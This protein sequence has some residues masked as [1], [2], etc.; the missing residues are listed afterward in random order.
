M[1]SLAVQEAPSNYGMDTGHS[2]WNQPTS[3]CS[4]HNSDIDSTE[5]EDTERLLDELRQL[6]ASTYKTRSRSSWLQYQIDW[7]QVEAAIAE[8]E[9]APDI[10][11]RHPKTDEQM[12]RTTRMIE[13]LVKQLLL[14]SRKHQPVEHVASGPT[15]GFKEDRL[16]EEVEELGKSFPSYQSPH[17]DPVAATEGRTLLNESFRRI[18]NKAVSDKEIVGKIC[19]NLLLS[20][21]APNVHNYNAL[22]AGFNRIQRP[23]LAQAVVDSYLD[24]VKWPATQ[25]T[26]VCLLDHARGTNDLE[27]FREIVG[28]MRGTLEDGLH[29]RILHKG[30][31][32]NELGAQW[33]RQYGTHRKNAYVERAPRGNEVFN[34]LIRG[35][36]HFGKVDAASMSF[37]SCLRNGRLVPVDTIQELLT[38]CLATLDQQTARA[39]LKGLAKNFEKFEALIQYILAQSSI[40]VARR[41]ADT[42]YALFD[43][44]AMPYKPVVGTVKKNLLDVVEAFRNLHIVTHAKLQI[45]EIAE[46][47]R[48]VIERLGSGVPLGVEKALTLPS[49]IETSSHWDA[50][51]NMRFRSVAILAALTKRV[52]TLEEKTQ[53]IDAHAKVSM[54]KY[55]IGYDIDPQSC[56]PP[57]DWRHRRPSDEYPALFYALQ[58]IRVG[59]KP[60]TIDDVKLQLFFGIPDQHKADKLA[61]K[62]INSGRFTQLKVQRLVSFY[63]QGPTHFEIL[64]L[65][66][67]TTNQTEAGQLE[68]QILAAEETTKNTLFCHLGKFRQKKLKHSYNNWQDIPLAEIFK[69]HHKALAH[70]ISEVR[71]YG[72][73]APHNIRKVEEL[74]APMMGVASSHE[75]PWETEATPP[76]PHRYMNVALASVPRQRP[77]WSDERSPFTS[78]QHE[79]SALY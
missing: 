8:E 57:I 7:V 48:V 70:R 6:A 2:T 39:M 16:L 56:L 47:S 25:Q 32:F 59:H 61:A 68:E 74:E 50:Q 51:A 23:D 5:A 53:R 28:R 66:S 73:I 46:S 26:I 49:S 14:R 55:Q 71:R 40:R 69:Y 3:D 52:Q 33:V 18:F 45:Q 62:F 37:V 13:R 30:A 76:P 63:E 67:D 72:A 20:S 35:W 58:C 75:R 4:G 29:F 44:C 36:L 10:S 24:D 27:H 41:I 17:T 78:M 65:G 31:I 1:S 79:G 22:I 21:A 9:R 54:L 11:L 60:V 34:S 42:F 15:D 77:L 64:S 12:Q 38:E 43:L 19:Y